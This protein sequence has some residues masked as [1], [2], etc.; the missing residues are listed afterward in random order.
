MKNI[1]LTT[2]QFILREAR[3]SD[4]KDVHEYAVDP[5]VYKFMPWG[6]NIIEDTKNYIQRAIDSRQEVPRTNFEL[7][8]ILKATQKT[9]KKKMEGFVFVCNSCTERNR[10][11]LNADLECRNVGILRQLNFIFCGGC[12]ATDILA[13]LKQ[14]KTKFIHEEL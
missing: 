3:K 11:Q 8:I 9:D 5:D 10:Q 14:S 7:A 12:R 2:E 6:P 13:R 1:K 4:W